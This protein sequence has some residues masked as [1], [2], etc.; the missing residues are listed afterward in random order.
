VGLVYIVRVDTLLNTTSIL[1]AV[2]CTIK[3]LLFGE[4]LARWISY[5]VVDYEYVLGNLV[6]I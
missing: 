5:P 1:L 6:K 3:L 4:N 2:L